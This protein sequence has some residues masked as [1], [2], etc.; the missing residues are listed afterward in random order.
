MR[1]RASFKIQKGD[2]EV[3]A[4]LPPQVLGSIFRFRGGA[5]SSRKERPASWKIDLDTW[6]GTTSHRGTNAKLGLI[7]YTQN[8]GGCWAPAGH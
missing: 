2:A 4:P 3:P 8:A 5:F 7:A 6:G 1:R